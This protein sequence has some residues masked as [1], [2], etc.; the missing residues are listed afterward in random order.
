MNGLILK[1]LHGVYQLEET[2]VEPKHLDLLPWD[3]RQ[4]G[5][6]SHDVHTLLSTR[7]VNTGLSASER[8]HT[9]TRCVL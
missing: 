4:H 5:P 6:M 2:S 1:P 3:L 7:W 9:Q 8:C